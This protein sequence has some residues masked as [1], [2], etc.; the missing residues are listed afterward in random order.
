M[1]SELP[2][3]QHQRQR[4]GGVRFLD[5]LYGQS[6]FLV[7][8]LMATSIAIIPTQPA[9]ALTASVRSVGIA[10]LAIIALDGG[11]L[12][13]LATE[14]GE[15]DL[16][17]DGDEGDLVPHVYDPGAG[18]SSN[19]G[20]AASS[21]L[22]LAA[23]EGGEFAFIANEG[24]EGADLNGDGDT[25]DNVAHVY[26]PATDVTANLGL[27]A[28]SGLSLTALDGG[29]LGLAPWEDAQG[30]DLNGDGDMSD[31][32]LHVY[33]PADSV[34]NVGITAEG[35]SLTALE[36]GRIA[37]L[38]RESAEG[39]DL[40]GD[41]DMGDSVPQ[42]YDPATDT[43]ANV[44]IAGSSIGALVGGS[45]AFF[46]S[47]SGEVVDLNGD[48][49]TDDFVP[50]VYDPATDTATNVGIAGFS[51]AALDGGTL[52]FLASEPGEGVDLNG[53]GDATDS[54]PHVYDPATDTAV[55]VGV[56]V[57][58]SPFIFGSPPVPLD[59]GRL[60][61]YASESG[62]SSHSGEGLDLNGD[63]DTSDFVPHVYDPVTD[64]ATN[65]GIAGPLAIL[66]ALDG[67]E[68]AFPASESGEGVDL[69]GD[70]DTDDFV[71]YVYDPA[72]DTAT[73]VGIALHSIAGGVRM[74]ALAGGNVAFNASESA[75]GTD[76]NADG[77]TEDAVPQVYDPA[78]DSAANMGIAANSGFLEFIAL[79]GGSVAFTAREMDQG[80]DF[81]GDDD[82]DDAVPHVASFSAPVVS[83]TTASPNP[84]L[85]GSPVALTALV[86]DTDT[87]GSVIA[88]ASYT[89][90]GGAP[91]PM[92]AAD[93]A[94]DEALEEV[95]AVIPAFPTAGGRQ[96]CVT[97]TDAEANTSDPQCVELVVTAPAPPPDPDPGGTPPPDPSSFESSVSLV[98]KKHLKAKGKVT[99]SSEDCLKQATVKIQRKQKKAWKTVKKA[100]SKATGAYA[101]KLR[102]RPGKYRAIVMETTLEGQ[103]CEQGVSPGRRHRH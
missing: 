39:A 62:E 78:A 33:D 47:E 41:G 72:T 45:A 103:I 56:A 22:D 50:Y 13:Y 84:A 90:A 97:G 21:L 42:I 46:A 15:G 88:S 65:V 85:V 36:G 14:F 48:G 61:F 53:D 18:A 31:F 91:V 6:S 81:N 89:V 73:N 51:L 8:L 55:N 60:G 49:D 94:F 20:I 57:P 95:T 63:G 99:S 80:M 10:G 70:G 28:L 96:V 58:G 87:G 40:N 9:G 68:L 44:G 98:L 71:P 67:G 93:G 19:V 30:A 32:V 38:T 24:W 43:T 4:H 76:L 54:V 79:E 35:F 12:G 52:A 7:A 29:R 64:T 3:P 1:G 69:N 77:D 101:T 11:M 26:D 27:G 92:N 100:I 37:F 23:L 82:A 59:G 102:D 5:R 75:E 74:T 66:P 86:D 2:G 17:G 25:F 34:A 83:G 16:N